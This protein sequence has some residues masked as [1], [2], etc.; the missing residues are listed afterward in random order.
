MTS[1]LSYEEISARCVELE[2]MRL[3]ALG[4]LR[5]ARIVVKAMG[6]ADELEILDTI[7]VELALFEPPKP[8]ITDLPESELQAS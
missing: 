6:R 4:G 5:M 3:S 2:R 7:I 8:E 1:E